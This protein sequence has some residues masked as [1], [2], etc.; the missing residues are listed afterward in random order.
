MEMLIPLA[1]ASA[2]PMLRKHGAQP[3]A[4]CAVLV[5]IASVLLSA[6]RGGLISLTFEIVLGA[7]L[8]VAF[9]PRRTRKAVALAGSLLL[10]AS[11]LLFVD[12]PRQVAA[13][14]AQMSTRTRRT[15]SWPPAGSRSAAI[16][17]LTPWLG[18]RTW[19]F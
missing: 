16:T 17:A 5:P 7:L 9:G 10:F 19:Q 2:L 14:L 11:A 18:V 4:A 6:S 12:G 15:R 3:I 1:A 13:H 8:L